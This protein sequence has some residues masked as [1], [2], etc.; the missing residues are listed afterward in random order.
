MVTLSDGS[1]AAVLRIQGGVHML[2]GVKYLKVRSLIDVSSILNIS[3][4]EHFSPQPAA[5]CIF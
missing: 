3:Y 1:C 5:H 4:P 2:G